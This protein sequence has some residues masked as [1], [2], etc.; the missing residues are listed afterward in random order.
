MTDTLSISNTSG[1]QEWKKMLAPACITPATILALDDDP[2]IRLV[3]EMILHQE[4]YHVLVT[5]RGK[6][7]FVALA[8]NHVQLILM[9]V[10]LCGEDGRDLTR[11]LKGNPHTREIPVILFSATPHSEA[12]I[13]ECGADDFL[14]KPFE[15]EN[16]LATISKH[17]ARHL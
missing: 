7:L 16:L 8:E 4:G 11:I 14:L 9:D 10:L 1:V 15:L 12:Y 2:D 6:E 17:L 5:S 13:L 3:V